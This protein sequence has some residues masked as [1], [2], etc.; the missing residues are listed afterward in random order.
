MTDS[1][2]VKRVLVMADASGNPLFTHD[3]LQAKYE[4]LSANAFYKGAA[5]QMVPMTID[6]STAQIVP[7]REPKQ[8]RTPRCA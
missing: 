3:L 2:R 4:V 5:G 7:R 6:Y 8:R 1:L